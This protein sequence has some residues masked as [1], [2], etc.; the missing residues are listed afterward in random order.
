MFRR[1]KVINAKGDIVSHGVILP[2]SG[3]VFVEPTN[4]DKGGQFMMHENLTVFEDG[5][6]FD[7]TDPK[8]PEIFEGAYIQY[9]DK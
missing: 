1:F 8:A 2:V 3:V 5:L 9:L 7:S 4:I 6:K